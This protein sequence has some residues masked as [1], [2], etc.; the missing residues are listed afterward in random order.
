MT[1]EAVSM[2][3]AEGSEAR[4]IASIAF[5]TLRKRNLPVA[6]AAGILSRRPA[7][8]LARER[9]A[10]AREPDIVRDVPAEE[11]GYADAGAACAAKDRAR[12]FGASSRILPSFRRTMRRA[13]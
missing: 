4:S 6:I 1:V 13:W 7:D 3:V 11:I 12:S 10:A 9:R 2:T 8:P 5:S